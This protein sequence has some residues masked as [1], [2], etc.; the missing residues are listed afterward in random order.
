MRKKPQKRRPEIMHP[1]RKLLTPL[2]KKEIADH[3]LSNQKRWE[4]LFSLNK[5]VLIK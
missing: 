3:L 1:G 2:E 5:W 4:H